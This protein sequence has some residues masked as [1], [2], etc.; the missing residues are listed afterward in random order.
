MDEDD[1]DDDDDA[2]DGDTNDDGRNPDDLGCRL[3]FLVACLLPLPRPR[4]ATASALA[5]GRAARCG[6]ASAGIA[7]AE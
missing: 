6:V 1:D 4:P 5:G 3:R 7:I 2:D